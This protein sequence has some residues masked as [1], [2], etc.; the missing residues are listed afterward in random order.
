MRK[1]FTNIGCLWGVSEDPPQVKKGLQM[2][3]FSCVE[4]AW[5]R[6]EAGVVTNY[7]SMDT[8]GGGAWAGEI[9]VDMKGRWL[10]PA[11]CD[12]HTH[13]VFAASRESEFVDALNGLSY[14]EIAA[15]GGG[16]LNSAQKLQQ[17][18]EDALFDQS[19]ERLH[20]MM[21]MG[22]GALEIKSGYGL[23]VADELKMLRVIARL[24]GS[25]NIPLKAT[26]LALHAVPQAFK[27][28]KAAFVDE[29]LHELIPAVASEGLAD[30]VDVFCELNY[31]DTNDMLRL[32]EAGARYGLKS[33]IHV[34]QFNAFGGL[35]QAVQA[36][37]LSVDHLEVMNAA[38]FE[39]LQVGST[40]A[41]VLPGCSFYLRI[42]YA[43]A[44]AMID[45]GLAVAI[46]SDF[47]PGSAPSYNPEL[48]VSLACIQ[49]RLLPE[50]ALNAATLN[51]AFAM[52]V[53]DVVGSI[54]PKKQANFVVTRPLPTLAYLPY[55]FG[56]QQVIE[57]WYAAERFS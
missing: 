50:E 29:M 53:A 8:L 54:T 48:S 3:E 32:M 31:F 55:A 24:K 22:V 43:P 13:L 6:T 47:N 15:R 30:F 21:A 4:N 23:T 37:A 40:I 35:V 45:A 44:R 10:L 28:H 38:D 9:E 51:G 19:F 17:M 56:E 12:S 41:T 18:E 26:C 25:V 14:A 11:F 57:T 7:G 39:A 1:L 5:L 27:M 36:G 46:A 52:D 2:R 20:K 49:Q 42:P 34:N 33:K 16:I